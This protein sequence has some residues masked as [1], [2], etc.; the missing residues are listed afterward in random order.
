MIIPVL[1]NLKSPQ[2]VG[3]IVRSHRAFGGTRIAFVGH[4]RP[5]KF[6][7]STQAFSRRLE[8]Q[9]DTVYLPDDDALL[10]WC[11]QSHLSCIALEISPT[12]I[13]LPHFQFPADI[14][15]VCG[16]EA[17]GVP[18]PLLDRCAATVVVPQTGTVGSLNVAMACS[19]ALYSYSV[20]HG[21]PMPID[22]HKFTGESKCSGEPSDARETSR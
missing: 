10:D 22:E 16:N 5:W 15:L 17:V 3:T 7:K 12:A 20:Q 19:I 2:N 1:H 6:K 13:Q 14:A 8:S 9:L 18:A 4:E 21:S 11:D